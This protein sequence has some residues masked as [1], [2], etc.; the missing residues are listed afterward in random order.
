MLFVL[1]L[2]L[3]P[4]EFEDRSEKKGS[5]HLSRKL[6]SLRVALSGSSVK[7]GAVSSEK[8]GYDTSGRMKSMTDLKSTSP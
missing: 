6:P 7:D 5:M 3:S 2:L 8:K 4:S 1:F